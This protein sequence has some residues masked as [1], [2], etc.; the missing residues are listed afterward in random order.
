MAI[1]NAQKPAIIAT[2][3]MVK[4]SVLAGRPFSGVTLFTSRTATAAKKSGATTRASSAQKFSP[5]SNNAQIT[6]TMNTPTKIHIP[7][8]SPRHISTAAAIKPAPASA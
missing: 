8:I 5:A 2:P 1:R 3:A 4:G 6:V 7:R